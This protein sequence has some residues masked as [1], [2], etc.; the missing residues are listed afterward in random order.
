MLKVS[1]LPPLDVSSPRSMSISAPALTA[2]ACAT[3]SM[4]MLS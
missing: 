2:M 3:G 1:Q 4:P